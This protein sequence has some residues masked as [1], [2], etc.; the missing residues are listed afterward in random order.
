MRVFSLPLSFEAKF[1]LE[2]EKNTNHP[3]ADGS[4]SVLLFRQPNVNIPLKGAGKGRKQL[5]YKVLLVCE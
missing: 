1:D 3:E 4:G 2:T 5:E